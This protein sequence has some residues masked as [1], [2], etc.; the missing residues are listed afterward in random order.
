MMQVEYTS[1]RNIFI[2]KLTRDF[3]ILSDGKVGINEPG[4]N[5]IYAAAG[6]GIWEQGPPPGLVARIGEDYPREW[7]DLFLQRGFDA[8]G[9]RVISEPIDSRFFYVFIDRT[10][11]IMDDPVPH[12]ARRRAISNGTIE[13]PGVKK[14]GGQ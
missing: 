13:L 6:L 2:G 5:V 9:I 1:P 4:G 10:T 3:Y 14:P 8:R 11:Q 7:I 12:F